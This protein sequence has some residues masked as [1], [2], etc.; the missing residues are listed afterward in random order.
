[1]SEAVTYK[2]RAAKARRLEDRLK[3]EATALLNELTDALKRKKELNNIKDL[4]LNIKTTHSSVLSQRS[5]DGRGLLHYAVCRGGSEQGVIELLVEE[6]PTAVPCVDCN[7]KTPLHLACGEK[8]PAGVIYLL[9]GQ[10]PDTVLLVDR[11]NQSLFDALEEEHAGHNVEQDYQND[12]TEYLRIVTKDAA[13][14]LVDTILHSKTNASPIV[15]AHLRKTIQE[16]SNLSSESVHPLSEQ[17][18]GL[19]ALIKHGELQ[20][21][22]KEEGFGLLVNGFLIMNKAGRRLA[23]NTPE[24][25]VKSISVLQSVINDTTCLFAHLIE[26]PSLCHQG[27]RINNLYI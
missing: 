23:L 10:R 20:A 13:R 11:A 24:E 2:N 19:H 8:L 18:Q 7:H 21:L 25:K 9:A 17:R 1:V 16:N 14:A 15:I 12:I 5:Q 27:I 4:V 3:E 26:N 6:C 22:L